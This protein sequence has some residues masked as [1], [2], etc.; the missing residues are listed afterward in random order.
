MADDDELHPLFMCDDDLA[1]AKSPLAKAL[2]QLP[3]VV[4]HEPPVALR[5]AA[6]KVSTRRWRQGAGGPATRRPAVLLR[7]RAVPAVPTAAAV[8]PSASFSDVLELMA[9]VAAM[10]LAGGRKR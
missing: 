5:V 8:S 2:K 10:K 9:G 7:S 1:T 3:R 4:R 6:G